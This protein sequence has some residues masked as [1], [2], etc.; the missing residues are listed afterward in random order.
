VVGSAPIKERH[1]VPFVLKLPTVCVS[2]LTVGKIFEGEG[3]KKNLGSERETIVQCA[4][5]GRWNFQTLVYK[6]FT[7][8][9]T[10]ACFV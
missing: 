9:A 10:A 1:S 3:Q 4:D 8:Q 5:F 7:D 2:S 6:R